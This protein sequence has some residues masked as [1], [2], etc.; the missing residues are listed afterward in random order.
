MLLNSSS[1]Y[2]VCQLLCSTLS[3]YRQR[4]RLF[5]TPSAVR[6][7]GQLPQ[8]TRSKT[9]TVKSDKNVDQSSVI[10]VSRNIRYMQGEPRDADA[11]VYR[12]GQKVSLV[13]FAITLSTASQFS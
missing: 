4:V 13:I 11:A 10:L 5:V 9:D 12:V 6:L 7:G 8:Y 2:S 3:N 1:I